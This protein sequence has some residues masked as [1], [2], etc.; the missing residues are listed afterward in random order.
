MENFQYKILQKDHPLTKTQKFIHISIIR[1]FYKIDV[2][3]P[4]YHGEGGEGGAAHGQSQRGLQLQ[5]LRISSCG[6]PD[7][8]L[9]D[10]C[11]L[12]ERENSPIE[13]TSEM[14]QATQSQPITSRFVSYHRSAGVVVPRKNVTM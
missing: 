2:Q 3:E 7:I 5:A 14:A 11:F 9:P 8:R 12:Q 1:L 10:R 4:E 13:P 6:S